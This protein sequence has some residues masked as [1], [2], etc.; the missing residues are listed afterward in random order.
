M[1]TGLAKKQDV[2][3]ISRDFG[4]LFS[5]HG[6][7]LKVFSVYSV[8][9]VVKLLDEIQLCLLWR[10]RRGGTFISRANVRVKCA[11]SEKPTAIAI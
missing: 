4:R 7:F 10:K 11:L 2:F 6:E 9:S 1:E 3:E 5:H 8:C